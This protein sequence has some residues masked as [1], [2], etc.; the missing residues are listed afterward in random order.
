MD[1][2]QRIED[3]AMNG[4]AFVNCSMERASFDDVNLSDSVFSNVSFHRA[5]LTNINLSGVAIEDADISGLKIMG[6][7]VEALI[8]DHQA[9]NPSENSDDKDAIRM[10]AEPQ[11]FVADIDAACQFYVEKLGFSVAFSHRQP[12]FYAQITR[13][14]CRLNLRRVG[15]PVFDVSFRDREVDALAATL[16]LDD[17]RPLF[18]EFQNAGVV[19]HQPLKVEPWGALTF[20]VQ[21]IDGNLIA[22]A[23]RSGVGEA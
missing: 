20:I 6:H 18:L 12:S 9:T 5:R 11:I 15:V 2:H 14:G 3:Q 7:D 10:F 19:F 21:D 4:A 22:F 23:G 8:R 13:G 17:A 1:E 16:T